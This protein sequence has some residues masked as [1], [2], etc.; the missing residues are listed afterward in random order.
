MKYRFIRTR[1]PTNEFLTNAAELMGDSFTDKRVVQDTLNYFNQDSEV[2]MFLLISEDSRVI[3][4]ACGLE[5]N[6]RISSNPNVFVKAISIGS[7]CVRSELRGQGLGKNF[8]EEL[9][10]F[11][12]KSSIE[13]MYLQGIY[14]FYGK[15]GFVNIL[16]QSKIRV[17]LRGFKSSVVPSVRNVRQDDI[18]HLHRIHK[19]M[20]GRHSSFC[21][22]RSE[23]RWS[24]LLSQGMRTRLFF[25]PTLV[26]LEKPLAY[27]TN[28]SE[29]KARIREHAY[30]GSTGAV[31]ALLTALRD[32]QIQ[33]RLECVE[34]MA[35]SESELI[36]ALSDRCSVSTIEFMKVNEGFLGKIVDYESFFQ[37][38]E[39]KTAI[40]QF[41]GVMFGKELRLERSRNSI[42]MFNSEG[43]LL[44]SII[45]EKL[46]GLIFGRYHPA[47]AFTYN[48]ISGNKFQN[49]TTAFCFQADAL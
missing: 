18:H 13:I 41:I 3:A 46:L 47:S 6:I 5:T 9:I 28:D 38:R 39:V 22:E 36:V 23:K 25:S 24:F 44:A 17:D 34:I 26:S 29:D 15:L 1:N 14:G 20:L 30:D 42:E 35:S 33:Q 43:E 19:E 37:N 32:Y 40:S 16:K 48:L 49:N 2:D 21:F 11:C 12:R 45:G 4:M 10:A 31:E 27:F 8:M 7:V